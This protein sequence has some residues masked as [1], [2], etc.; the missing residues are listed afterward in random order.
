[1]APVMSS[2]E[3]TV[4]FAGVTFSTNLPVLVTIVCQ[5]EETKL[6]V[7]CEKMVI[8]SMLVKS[9]KEVLSEI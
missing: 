3:T 5:E 4:R 6:T 8:N 9:I 1:M 7:N 2:D